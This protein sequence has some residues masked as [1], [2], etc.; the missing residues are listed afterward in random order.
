M[1]LKIREGLDDLRK[2]VASQKRMADLTEKCAAG[3]ILVA[4]FQADAILAFLYGVFM[5]M[6]AAA[7]SF[8]LTRKLEKEGA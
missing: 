7:V 6:I 8:R 5:G 2:S 3:A 4:F 1:S